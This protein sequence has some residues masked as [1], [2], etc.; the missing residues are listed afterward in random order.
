M[1]IDEIVICKHC[2][3]VVVS[4]ERGWC[5]PI[6]GHSDCCTAQSPQPG[7][8]IASSP[9]YSALP[10]ISF[11]ELPN[12]MKSWQE[13]ARFTSFMGFTPFT[14]FAMFTSLTR[15]NHSPVSLSV[16]D[17]KTDYYWPVSLFHPF[18]T[19]KRTRVF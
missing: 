3:A 16:K 19:T 8:Q 15:S 6:F 10:Q 9:P 4:G 12:S 14:S 11:S 2:S 7:E 13:Q 18:P 1:K 5:A 17:G